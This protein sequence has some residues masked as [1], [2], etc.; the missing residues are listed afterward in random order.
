MR[1]CGFV[2]SILAWLVSCLLSPTAAAAEKEGDRLPRVCI[3]HSYDPENFVTRPQDQGIVEGLAAAGFVEGRSVEIHRFYMDTKKTF[4]KPDQLETR[5]RE[6]LRKIRALDPDLVFTVDDN[7]ARM[8]MFPLIDT[9]IPIVFSG[10]NNRPEL[11]N[12][13]RRFMES[14]QEPR[15]NVTGVYEK[16]YIGKSVQV[17]QEILPDLKKIVFIVDDSPTG[18][19]IKRQMEEEL[20]ALQSGLLYSI[21]QVGCVDTYRQLI[22]RINADP[23]VGAYYPVAVRLTEAGG[24]IVTNAEILQWTLAHAR[25]PD[26]A[27]NYYI[28]RLGAMGGVSV[29]FKAM[30]RQAGA[31]GAKILNGYPV[32]LIPV[33]DAAAYALVFNI[34]RARQLG[35][36][37]PPDLLASSDKLYETMQLSATRNLPKVLIVHS[38]A[39]G[40]GPGTE[41][42]QGLLEQL[43]ASGYVDG[44]TVEINRFYMRA[45]RDFIQPEEVRRRGRAALDE[46]KRLQ[47]ELVITLND[48]PAQEVMLPLVNSEYPVLFGGITRAPEQ[49]NQKIRFMDSRIRPG[50]N[51]SGVTGEFE[52]RKTLETALVAFP[53]TDKIV[54]IKGE[55]PGEKTGASYLDQGIAAFLAVHPGVSVKVE[56]VTDVESFKQMVRQ[57]NED[58]ETDIVG[59]VFPLEFIQENGTLAPLPE[60]LH[61]LFSNLK[62]PGLAFT[63]NWIR[64]GYLMGTVI[65]FE[66]VGRQLGTQAVEVLQGA[67]PGDLPVQKPSDPYIALN[68]ARAEQLG[69][70]L[71]LDILEAA[72]RVYPIMEVDRSH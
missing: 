51:V 45:G 35:V 53:D 30:G 66:E 70:V 39:P 59:S 68:M 23:E 61:W 64:Y 52:V 18:Y 28:C 11:Y 71:S 65:N 4:I 48:I 50:H 37:I 55:L 44:K 69:I 26:L 47:P 27:V 15:H 42:E 19:A 2:F 49:L 32:G 63:D 40:V 43:A 34:A 36:T 21:Q 24:R 8:V 25:K 41:I 56:Q 57:Y 62:K 58:P 60:I 9:E 54:L 20:F 31:K 67:D 10:I 1:V 38:R 33:E 7:A 72:D 16:L 17:M 29:D 5:G 12:H 46:V 22:R 3:V 13:L 14:R 6:A